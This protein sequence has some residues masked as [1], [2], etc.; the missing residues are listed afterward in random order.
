MNNKVDVVTCVRDEGEW[1]QNVNIKDNM[2]T[3]AE[4]RGGCVVSRNLEEKNNRRPSPADRKTRRTAGGGQT[5]T[6]GWK[7]E[8]GNETRREENERSGSVRLCGTYPEVRVFVF[9][10]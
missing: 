1:V 4:R 10:I 6:R 9:V 7:L 2:E 3:R 5:K 8:L